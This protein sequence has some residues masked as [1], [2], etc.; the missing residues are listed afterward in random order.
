MCSNTDSNLDLCSIVNSIGWEGLCDHEK[1][2]RECFTLTS[3]YFC[4]ST[5]ASETCNEIP[6]NS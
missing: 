6:C 2:E 4:I 3:Y 1:R 5:F